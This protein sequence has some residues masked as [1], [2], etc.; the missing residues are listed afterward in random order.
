MHSRFYLEHSILN[1][2]MIVRDAK[3][4]LIGDA[5]EICT[6][7]T[8]GSG[9]I[10]PETGPLSRTAPVCVQGDR[11]C[12]SPNTCSTQVQVRHTSLT[13]W[14]ERSGKH[15]SSPATAVG[16][17]GHIPDRLAIGGRGSVIERLPRQSS[18]LACS[19]PAGISV[20]RC[21]AK[22]LVM[23]PCV[24][25]SREGVPPRYRFLRASSCLRSSQRL[26]SSLRRCAPV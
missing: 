20:S 3:R 2:A 5:N 21:P 16:D 9:S 7:A 15:S 14:C 24:N 12:K 11:Q 6:P 17:R 18:R 8:D 23:S 1:C 19:S 13:N 4:R 26:V 10:R 25:A 22:S